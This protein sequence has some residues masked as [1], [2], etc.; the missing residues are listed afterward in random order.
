[1]EY[2]KYIIEFP[3]YAICGVGYSKF[4][5]MAITKDVY[6]FIVVPIFALLIAI[7]FSD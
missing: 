2:I 5:H 4:Y 6:G 3:V 1:M 7:Y